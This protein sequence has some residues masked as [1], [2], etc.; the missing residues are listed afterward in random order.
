MSPAGRVLA[1]QVSLIQCIKELLKLL[2][3][4]MNIRN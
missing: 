3:L 1:M 4:P 2:M